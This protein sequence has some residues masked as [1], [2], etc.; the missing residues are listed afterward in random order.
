MR[1]RDFRRPHLRTQCYQVFGCTVFQPLREMMHLYVECGTAI[2][3]LPVSSQG[4]TAEVVKDLLLQA[5][6]QERKK[7]WTT[8]APPLKG[9]GSLVSMKSFLPKDRK[10]GFEQRIG[11]VQPLPNPLRSEIILP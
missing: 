7:G 1:A 2:R 8:D 10:V 6:V 4:L 9:A 5:V 11:L 3:H